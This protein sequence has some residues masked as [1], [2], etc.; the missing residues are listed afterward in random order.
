[1]ATGSSYPANVRGTSG[2]FGFSIQKKAAGKLINLPY[3]KTGFVKSPVVSKQKNSHKNELW[4]SNLI[5]KSRFDC[6]VVTHK[7]F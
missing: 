2:I 3:Y 5:G 4:L 1:M 6:N 7:K